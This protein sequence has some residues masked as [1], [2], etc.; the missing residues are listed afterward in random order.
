MIMKTNQNK[1][2]EEVVNGFLSNKGKASVY[3]FEPIDYAAPVAEIIKNVLSKNKGVKIFIAVDSYPT[4]QKVIGKLDAM[5]IDKTDIKVLS[6]D[7]I[8]AKYRYDYFLTVTIGLNDNYPMLYHLFNGAKFMLSVITK[9]NMDNTFTNSIR[10]VLPNINTTV[11]NTSVRAENIYL[12]VEEYRHGVI[13][14]DDDKETYEKY[15]DYITTS[16]RI[17]G[18]IS[19]IEKCRIGDNVFNVSA[20][21]VRDSIA[22]NN[23]WSETLDTSIGFNKQIDD[24]YNPNS[25]YERA[26]NFYNITKQR[27]NLVMDNILKLD[28]I[29]SICE[30]HKDKK[31]LIVSKRGEF[32]SLITKHLNDLGIVKC[33][34]YHDSIENA[35]AVNEYGEPIL[36]KS[37][38]SKGQPKILG[39]QAISTLNMRL[40]NNSDINV[41]SIKNSSSNKLKIGVDVLIITSPLCDG[42]IA[43]KTRFADIDFRV[44]PNIVHKIYTIGTIENVTMNKEKESPLIKVIDDNDNFIG[45]DENSGDIIL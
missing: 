18:D 22:R 1:Y 23:G 6:I 36:I 21:D 43:L 32:A 39:A 31:I 10:S 35:V 7:Y 30:K 19:V 29:A 45:Y 42:V 16:V 20:A 9:N 33:G 24:A 2:N 15:V 14:T 3:C 17:F 34:D 37:G 44:V 4:R 40:F 28:A 13:M 26:N 5:G 11:S 8:N 25:L 41:L 38:K 27:R 12:P